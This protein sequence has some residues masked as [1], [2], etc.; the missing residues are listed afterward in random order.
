VTKLFASVL[1]DT[2]NHQRFIEQAIASVLEQDFPA[3]ERE[4]VVVDDGSTD[5]TPAI[6]RKFEPHVRLLRKANGGQASAF[7]TGIRECKGEIIAFLDGDDWWASG[8]LRKVVSQLSEDARCGIIGHGIA[9]AFEDGKNTLDAV[10]KAERLRLNSLAAARVFRL[11]KSY[12]GTSRMTIRAKIA[13]QLLPVPELL[14]IEADEYLFTLAAVLS[15][16]VIFP[17]VLSYYRHHGGNLYSAAGGGD[18]NGLRRKQRIVAGLAAALRRELPARNVPADAVEC[19]CEILEREAQ[20]MRLMLDGG[21]PWETLRVESA[22]YR[23]MHADAPLS[24]RIFRF[25]SMIPSLLLPP[26][27]FY[28]S[29]RWLGKRSWYQRNRQKVL[30]VPKVTSVAGAEEF[31]A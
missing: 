16:L 30:P 20:Q 19:I 26:R 27:W 11:R 2:Y 17:D 22:I 28:S 12:L 31:K 24:H 5:R 6:V 1:I 4:I 18:A 13:R 25:A 14:T 7:N 9:N 8:K 15:E 29:R 21:A 3:S 10:D 23:I